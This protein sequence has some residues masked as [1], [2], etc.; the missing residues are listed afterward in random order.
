MQ[1]A[2]SCRKFT[3]RTDPLLSRKGSYLLH[4]PLLLL[5]NLIQQCLEAVLWEERDKQGLFESTC[6]ASLNCDG[7]KCVSAWAAHVTISSLTE[8]P[9]GMP[10]RDS[11]PFPGDCDNNDWRWGFDGPK[12]PGNESSKW[13]RKKGHVCSC[14]TLCKVSTKE[15]LAEQWIFMRLFLHSNACTVKGWREN[16]LGFQ[17]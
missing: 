15:C 7:F 9:L 6:W 4:L 10:V 16:F 11:W 2:K 3:A 14:F 12:T 1:S 8:R 13:Q 5:N 17:N